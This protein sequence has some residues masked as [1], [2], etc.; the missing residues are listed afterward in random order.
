MTNIFIN[1]IFVRER[2]LDETIDY[3]DS[4]KKV[5]R[6]EKS[7][8]RKNI[9]LFP[10]FYSFED[11]YLSHEEGVIYAVRVSETFSEFADLSFPVLYVKAKYDDRSAIR[12]SYNEAIKKM[13]TPLQLILRNENHRFNSNNDYVAD[14]TSRRVTF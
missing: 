8:N 14:I 9:P 2:A 6:R 10:V 7:P 11:A 5:L 4:M 1:S 3:R 13:F 12:K